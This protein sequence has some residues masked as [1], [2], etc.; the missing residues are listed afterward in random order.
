MKSFPYLMAG[1]LINNYLK[2][3]LIMTSFAQEKNLH[4]GCVK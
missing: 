1:Y 2:Y 3:T 4:Q